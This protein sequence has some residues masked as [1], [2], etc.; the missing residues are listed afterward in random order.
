LAPDSQAAKFNLSLLHSVLPSN[1]QSAEKDQSTMQL[2][3]LPI[4]LP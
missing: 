4:G 1:L 2:S 3:N